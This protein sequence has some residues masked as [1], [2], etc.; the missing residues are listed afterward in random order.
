MKV[1]SF[2]RLPKTIATAT[3]R[4]RRDYGVW[5]DDTVQPPL[6]KGHAAVLPDTTPGTWPNLRH[7]G[8]THD[9]V[10]LPQ[11]HQKILRS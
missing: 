7:F 3:D 9:S 6:S 1:T 2:C 8:F 5:G 4:G 10:L 11:H